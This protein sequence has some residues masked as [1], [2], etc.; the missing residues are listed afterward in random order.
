MILL[1]DHLAGMRYFT[2][3][4]ILTTLEKY[5]V[6]YPTSDKLV[7]KNNP[8]QMNCRGLNHFNRLS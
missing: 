4:F 3:F 2:R 6:L 7:T 1:S 5:G 8:L